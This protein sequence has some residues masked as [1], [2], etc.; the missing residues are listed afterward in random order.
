MENY[1]LYRTNVLLGGQMKYDIILGTDNY[2]LMV[3]NFNITPI[4]DNIYYD[5]YPKS[6]IRNTSSSAN[7]SKHS[8]NIKDFGLGTE[9]LEEKNN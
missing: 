7:S 9:K 4:S 6:L 8:D 5:K 3:E 2:G 1:Q